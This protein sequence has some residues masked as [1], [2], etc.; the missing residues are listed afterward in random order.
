MLIGADYAYG[1]EVETKDGK[2]TGKIWGDAIEAEW[3]TQNF[4]SNFRA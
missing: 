3:K 2:L 4:M 1:I